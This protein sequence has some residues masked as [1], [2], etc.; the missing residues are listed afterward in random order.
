MIFSEVARHELLQTKHVDKVMRIFAGQEMNSPLAS[1]LPLKPIN[2]DKVVIDVDLGFRG[3]MT[4]GIAIGAEHPLFGQY[5]SGRIEFSAVRWGEKVRISEEEL[6]DLRRLGTLSELQTGSEVLNRKYRDVRFRLSRRLE[7]MRREALFD[8]QVMHPTQDG[9]ER[10]AAVYE[11]PDFLKFTAGTLWSNASADPLSD[12]MEWS[13]F[14]KDYS[15]YQINRIILPHGT[16]RMLTENTR[17]LNIAT[18]SHMA[19]DGSRQSV[20]R[21]MANYLGLGSIEESSAKFDFV[22]QLPV[23][24]ASGATTVVI[25]GEFS[26]LEVGDV[27]TFKGSNRVMDQVTVTGAPTAQANGTWSIPCSATTKDLVAGTMAKFHRFVIP[28][29]QVLMLGSPLGPMSDEGTQVPPELADLAQWGSVVTT[30]NRVNDLDRPTPGIYTK[31]IDKLTNH[32]PGHIEQL[33]G[34]NALPMIEYSHA[35]ATA[36]IR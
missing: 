5:G 14:F 27:I 3:G 13:E 25:K 7:W 28:K 31:L 32:D 29:D 19:F 6:V 34:I 1:V 18:N 10:V 36:T 8:G 20:A 2:A 35:W 11:R 33:I 26:K 30:Y 12:L 17:F 21:I 9:I 23:A 15:D 4:P 16:L 24:V 22:G